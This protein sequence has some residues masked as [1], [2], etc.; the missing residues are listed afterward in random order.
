M[1][2]SGLR[3]VSGRTWFNGLI[4]TVALAVGL[5]S[6]WY[7][8]VRGQ[9]AAWGWVK[10]ADPKAGDRHDDEHDHDHHD[11]AP[12]NDGNWIEVSPQAQARLGLDV[13]PV[14]VHK[15]FPVTVSLPAIVVERPGRSVAEVTAP[16]TGA[17]LRIH[18]LPGE[19]VEPGQPLFELRM[20]HEELVQAQTELLK[21]VEELDVIASEVARLEKATA[22]GAVAGKTLLDR[23]YEQQKAEGLLRSQKQALLL[24]HLTE[25]H[26][27]QILKD[28]KLRETLTVFAPAI[29]T[30]VSAGSGANA[31][32]NSAE[33]QTAA[34]TGPAYQVQTLNV[35]LGQ[36]VAAGD[37]LCVLAD[38]REL[39]LEGTA[40]PHDIPT[41]DRIVEN[42]WSLS[43][44]IDIPG[45]GKDTKPQSIDG[46]KV[47]YI[48]NRVDRESRGFSFFLRLPNHVLRDTRNERGQR[49]VS[50][51]FKPGQRMQLKAPVD[52]WK[53]QLVAPAGAIV[54]EGAETFVFQLDGDH[55]D[56]M[57]VKLIY[58][59]Q[60][61]GV[62]DP[63]GPIYAGDYIAHAGAHQLQLA[64]KNKLSGPIDPHAGHN[65]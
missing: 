23:K 17:I 20:T 18:A 24:H 29:A 6:L 8:R 65:H 47:L 21:T 7:P 38:H 43:A 27:E 31:S 50:W 19:A 62:L 41:L 59:D 12:H 25:Q 9:L 55:F 13:R 14:E 37:R 57:P 1:A 51:Q 45:A 44:L 42:N 46:L 35:E 56:R 33:S 4:L 10:E 60:Q 52:V 40:F 53:D 11:H 49:F 39:Y 58:R 36:H 2:I 54:Q 15:E 3:G 30:D 64:L 16:L 48:A 26:V 28:R 34:A 5:Q 32:N 22:G 63:N 61:W